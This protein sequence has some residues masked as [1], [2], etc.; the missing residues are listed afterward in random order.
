MTIRAKFKCTSVTKIVGWIDRDKHPFLYS[1]KMLVVSSGSEE[2]K[3]FFA[4]TPSGE[5]AVSAVGDDLF[6][7]G[8]E[9]YVDFTPAE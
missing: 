1:Y 5:L 8:K 6:Q 2:N 4:S 9:Y 7:V 3:K